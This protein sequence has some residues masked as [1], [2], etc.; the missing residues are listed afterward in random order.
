MKIGSSYI[1]GEKMTA[2]ELSECFKAL[3]GNEY[4][5]KLKTKLSPKVLAETILGFESY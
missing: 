4:Q 2:Q 5:E 1:I 3:L